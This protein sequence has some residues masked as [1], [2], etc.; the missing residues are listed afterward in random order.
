MGHGECVSTHEVT[1]LFHERN[2]PFRRGLGDAEPSPQRK[3]RATEIRKPRAGKS[4]LRA[5]RRQ[6]REFSNAFFRDLMSNV[7]YLA[8]I[9]HQPRREAL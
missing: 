3:A 1:T 8:R 5:G 4:T 6:Q 9:S 7:E 2:P